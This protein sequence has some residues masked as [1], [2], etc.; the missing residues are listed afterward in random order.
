[1]HRSPGV[2]VVL[3]DNISVDIQYAYEIP[4][5]ILFPIYTYLHWSYLLWNL[6]IEETFTVRSNIKP[7]TSWLVIRNWTIMLITN[8]NLV[9]QTIPAENVTE[10]KKSLENEDECVFSRKCMHIPVPNFNAVGKKWTGHLEGK[11]K[12][13]S[14][15]LNKPKEYIELLIY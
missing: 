15:D 4:G 12:V 6:P 5:R 10:K 3:P 2:P 11:Q 14:Y 9:T 13:Q 1:M 7:W 8:I